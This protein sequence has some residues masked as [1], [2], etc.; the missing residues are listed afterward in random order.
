MILGKLSVRLV[1]KSFLFETFKRLLAPFLLSFSAL[2]SGQTLVEA[3]E[4]TLL[5]NPN[6][7]SSATTWTQPMRCGVKPLPVICR[8]SIWSSPAALKNRTTRQPEP[9]GM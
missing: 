9:P 1:L 4:Q 3:I 5:T 7:Q 6:I 2:S 8:A